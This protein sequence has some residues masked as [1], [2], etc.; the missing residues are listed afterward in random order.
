[1]SFEKTGL[2]LPFH[3][4][5]ERQNARPLGGVSRDKFEGPR[6]RPLILE[7]PTI[8]LCLSAKMGTYASLEGRHANLHYKTL[9]CAVTHKI[10]SYTTQREVETKGLSERASFCGAMRRKVG[11][12][13]WCIRFGSAMCS[14]IT[15][16]WLRPGH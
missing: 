14:S 4:L 16:I 5:V 8:D 11:G 2:R 7:P 9:H 1:M 15:L 12:G 13:P 6:W 3:N 10:L